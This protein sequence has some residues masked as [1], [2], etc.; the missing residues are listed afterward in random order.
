[1]QTAVLN[2]ETKRSQLFTPAQEF[3]DGGE[4]VW[5]PAS[6][7]PADGAD[8]ERKVA[9][10]GEHLGHASEDVRGGGAVNVAA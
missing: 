3:R 5:V 9:K 2:D 4:Q 1:M 6:E 10:E 7:S 8:C